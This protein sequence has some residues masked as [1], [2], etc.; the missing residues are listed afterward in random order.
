MQCIVDGYATYY[1]REGSGPLVLLLH[2]WGDTSK[3][4]DKL[5]H[6]IKGNFEFISLDLPG[7]G[8]T[9]SPKFAFT[10]SDYADF[11]RKFFQKI[12]VST[13]DCI[14]GHS[15]G[16]AIA[17]KA[18]ELNVLSTKKIVLLASSGIRSP[19]APKTR[20]IR[21]AAKIVKLPTKLLPTRA[22]NKL[23]RS[24]YKKLGSD[25][26]V[27]EH[28]QDTFKNI[29]TEDLRMSSVSIRIPTLLIYG[30]KDTSTPAEYG[31]IFSHTIK[32]SRLE[33]IVG[34]DHFLHQTHAKEVAG[35]IEE[36]I[37]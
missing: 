34:A 14:V 10:L 28:L 31:E 8:K 9:E 26:F 24:A 16:G 25:L 5:K 11:I 1:E 4:F 3:T 35:L 15:N 13:V 17:I 30:G 7:F 2:G 18:L 23:K 12:D 21:I 22:Q 29:V 19:Y 6:E 33:V 32:N 36:F 20:A 37:G 27:A